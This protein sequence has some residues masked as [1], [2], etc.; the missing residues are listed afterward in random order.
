ML[1]STLKNA[2]HGSIN[3]LDIAKEIIIELKDMSMKCSKLKCK[4]RELKGKYR[5]KEKKYWRQK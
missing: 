2:F 1:R 5:M 3:S 4:K